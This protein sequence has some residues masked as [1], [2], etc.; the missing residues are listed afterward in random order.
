M[1]KMKR[2]SKPAK[3]LDDTGDPIEFTPAKEL[4]DSVA[5]EPEEPAEP[6]QLIEATLTD[7]EPDDLGCVVAVDESGVEHKLMPGSYEGL[8]DRIVRFNKQ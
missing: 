4:E 2:D 8:G 7:A 6:N 3:E 1:A 5:A